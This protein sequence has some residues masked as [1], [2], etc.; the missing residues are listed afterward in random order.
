[1]EAGSGTE[2]VIGTDVVGAADVDCIYNGP[3]P[4]ADSMLSRPAVTVTDVAACAPEGLRQPVMRTPTLS[5]L[6]IGQPLLHV[7]ATVMLLATHCTKA[8]LCATTV[9]FFELSTEKLDAA[10]GM[11]GPDEK[12]RVTLSPQHT[13]LADTKDTVAVTAAASGMQN[14]MSDKKFLLR[15]NKTNDRAKSRRTVDRTAKAQLR[16]QC[17][18]RHVQRKISIHQRQIEAAV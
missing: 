6:A 8:G 14:C 7:N 4:A 17:P 11:L 13:P 18:S 2:D 5:P 15:T 1:M 12:A 10:Q 9:P 3:T 16:V